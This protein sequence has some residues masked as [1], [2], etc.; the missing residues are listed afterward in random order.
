MA[1]RTLGAAIFVGADSSKGHSISFMAC[2][3]VILRMDRISIFYHLPIIC[4]EMV[5][6]WPR[7]RIS[8]ELTKMR[9]GVRKL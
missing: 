1:W 5:A 6:K 9:L 3:G 4:Q 8:A 7:G 2:M